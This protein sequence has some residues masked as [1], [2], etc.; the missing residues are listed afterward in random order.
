MEGDDA[1]GADWYFLAGLGIA[2]GELRLVAQLEV[3]EAGE[4]DALAALQRAAD[5]LEKRLDH[6]LSLALVQPDLLEQEVGQLGLR[7]SHHALPESLLYTQSCGEFAA[8]QGDQRVAGS[9]C[10]R[11]RKGS[12]SMLHNYPERKAFSVGR[13]AFA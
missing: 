11:I 2:P 3:A 10:L 4:L 8:Q 7:Q 5:F 6:V 12:F 13:D 1:A 9:V